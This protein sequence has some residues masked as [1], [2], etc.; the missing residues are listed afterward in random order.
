[1]WPDRVS[2][3]GPL[4]YESGALPT[5]LRS[6]AVRMELIIYKNLT[7]SAQSAH[8][9]FL[10][11]GLVHPY[12]FTLLHSEWPKLYGVLAVLSA[13]GLNK[14]ISS[15]RGFWGMLIIF[16]VFCIEIPVSRQCRS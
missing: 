16:I 15:F 4:T 8:L 14:S 11:S 9:T 13:T 7:D 6:P 3:P 5:A 1:M 10:T 12:Q 2:N